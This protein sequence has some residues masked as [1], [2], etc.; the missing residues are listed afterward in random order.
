MKK[1][2]LIL[3]LFIS[4]N[5]FAQKSTAAAV[6]I[7]TN[8]VGISPIEAES[9]FRIE[10]TKSN[11][12]NVY[13]KQDLLE[14]SK[15]N[16][17]SLKDCY[18]KDCLHAIGVA[19]KVDKIV[20]GSIE[21]LGKRVI[22]TVKILDVLSNTYDKTI[23]EEFI[24]LEREI[25]LMIHMTLNK[26]LGIENNKE[27]LEKLVYYNEPLQLPTTRVN[28]S[29]PRMG[30]AYVGGEINEVLTR[31]EK[32][33]GYEVQPILSQFGY[34]IE[35]VYLSSGNFQALAEGMFMMTGVEQGLFSP[36]FVFM[37]GF[38]SSKNGWEIAFGPSISFKRSARGYYDN[39]NTW[40]LESEWNGT[41]TEYDTI[42]NY[43]KYIDNPNPY[44]VERRLDKRGDVVVTANWVWAIGKT[45]HSGYLNIPVNAYFSHSKDG[46]MTGLS[47]GFNIARK[48]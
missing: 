31:D 36:S 1:L 43:T 10:L 4:T 3:L 21:H 33:G 32:D 8:G 42:N 35:G 5:V 30:L 39:Q 17:I 40:H 24:D 48:D 25:Q 27:Y 20:T 9:L 26:A 14:V 12:Y 37:N 34:Q 7:F 22:V 28:N 44:D 23:S 13:D 38:R 46:W 29:G 11:I 41:I 2:T 6:N 45:F 47:V 18:G 15:K 19:A 16:D